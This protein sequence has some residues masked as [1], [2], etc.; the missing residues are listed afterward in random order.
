MIKYYTGIGSTKTPNEI[1]EYMTKV[2]Y[3]LGRKNYILRSGHAPRADY[4]FETGC[5][6]AKGEK[7][8]YIPW[9]GF[10]GSNSNLIV[11][12]PNAF[13]MA[14][15]FHPYWN[16][17]TQGVKK[18]HARNCHQVL[19]QDLNTPT[20]FILCWTK[21]GKGSGGTGQALRIAKEFNIPIFDLGR[22]DKL[23]NVKEEI[24]LF[25]SKFNI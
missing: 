12:D 11:N 14:E 10:N 2:A 17:L 15:R 18:L 5:D 8:I 22:Y 21:N 9:K 13:N 7:E 19:G 16:G 23:N 1:C 24:V 25:L 6:L 4:A 3:F 20:E